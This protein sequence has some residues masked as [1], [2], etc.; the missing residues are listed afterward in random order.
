MEDFRREGPRIDVDA[1]CW[2]VSDEGET[3]AMAVDLSQGGIR[4]E[5]PYVGGRTREVVP[6]QLDIPG[7]DELLW[8]RGDVC[9]D[10]VV[11]GKHRLAPLV[12]RTGYRIAMAARRDR[13]MLRE[14]VFDSFL[15]RQ[16]LDESGLSHIELARGSVQI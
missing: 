4:I 7:I 14:Y 11:A 2:E 3:S 10:I 16:R 15:M 12:R 5:R 13:K 1:L 8:A 6:L 9:S